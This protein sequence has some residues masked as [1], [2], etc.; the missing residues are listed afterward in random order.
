MPNSR[1]YVKICCIQN[2]AEAQLAVRYGADLLGLVGRMPSGPGMIGEDTAAQIAAWTPPGVTA[3]LLTMETQADVIIEQQKRTG[4]GALQLVDHVEPEQ[5]RQVREALP[6]IDLIQVIHVTGPEVVA[7]AVDAAETSDAILLDSGTPDA[8]IKVLGGTGKAHDWKVSREIV[9]R[10]GK[11]VFLAGGLNAG[12]VREAYE[13][14]RPFG[15]DICSGIRTEMQL[16][17]EKL[18]A[19]MEAVRG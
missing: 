8:E 2:L 10:V 5:H 4:V 14:V 6:G 9:Q 3:V 16:V 17:E 7:D 13:S 19:Y 15:V 11:P 1:P 18:A 12:N